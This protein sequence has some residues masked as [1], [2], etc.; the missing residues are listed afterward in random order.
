MARRS[1]REVMKIAL[2]SRALLLLLMVLWRLLGRPYDTSASL[3]PPC[4]SAQHLPEDLVRGNNGGAP[5]WGW[6]A[7]KIESS[8]VWDSVY[9]VRIAQCSYEYEQT[10]AF[11]PVFPLALRLISKTGR[12]Y[13]L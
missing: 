2:G 11:L 6:M 8:I 4:L 10:F 5:L 1:Q 9:Y 12:W 3:D 13:V 7:T